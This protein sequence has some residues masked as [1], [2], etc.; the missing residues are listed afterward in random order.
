MAKTTQ[1][2]LKIF[3]KIGVF[4]LIR[5]LNSDSLTVLN[6]HRIDDPFR[7]SFNTFKPNVS[8]TPNM[9]A[10]QMAYLSQKYNVV[11]GKEIAGW[12]NEGSKLP[13][14]AAVITFDDGYYDNL[15]NAYPVLKTYN[16]PAIIFLTTDFIDSSQPFYWDVIA[17]AFENSPKD[18]ADIPLLGER[19]WID[20]ESRKIIMD[21]WIA[22]AKTLP[23]SDKKKNVYQIPD[24]LH[25]S[26]PDNLSADLA[27]TWSHIRLMS[28]NGIEMGSHTVSHP[29][30]TRI[31]LEDVEVEL[32]KSKN[33]IETEI[34]SSVASFAYPNGQYNDFN[35]DIVE[36]VKR[37]GYQIAFT[38]LPGPARYSNVRKEPFTIRRIFLS[39]K[40][41][42]PKF[43]GKLIGLSKI[44]P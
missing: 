2:I 20:V 12:V 24:I 14:N 4:D 31:S 27:L 11:S 25:V 9:F 13:P 32:E 41:S 35:D 5:N 42:F 44:N 34:N 38:L 39:Y 28:E 21:E 36:R 22:V 29:I 15:A 10:K 43:V 8:A 6:Y 33:R 23:E 26:I 7:T 40:D 30:L 16:L 19:H 37:A 1:T 3:L 18:H 17:Y